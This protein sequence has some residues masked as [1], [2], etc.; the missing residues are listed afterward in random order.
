MS[1]TFVVFI[2]VYFSMCHASF[3]NPYLVLISRTD[4]IQHGQ[5][6]LDNLAEVK[7]PI[8]TRY[9][10]WRAN[11]SSVQ[12]QASA[13]HLVPKPLVAYHS[14]NS[15]RTNMPTSSSTLSKSSR[16]CAPIPLRSRT[17]SPYERG[18]TPSPYE[19]DS[20]EDDRVG[21]VNPLLPEEPGAVLSSSH[22]LIHFTL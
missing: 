9:E 18:R 3:S 7:I 12:P 11:P 16:S 15:L 20:T 5:E 8:M 19:Q 2:V 10:Q 22:H 6:I 1:A 13:S 21:H 17:P 4:H 14:T